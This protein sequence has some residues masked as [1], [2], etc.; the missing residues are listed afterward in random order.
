MCQRRRSRVPILTVTALLG[1][2]LVLP[3]SPA[4]AQQLADEHREACQEQLDQGAPWDTKPRLIPDD[5]CE[6]L[7]EALL[8]AYD[9]A[10][11]AE[12]IR[13]GRQECV[14]ML[15]GGISDDLSDDEWDCLEEFAGTP[16]PSSQGL[17]ES[18]VASAGESMW[19]QLYDWMGSG[20]RWVLQNLMDLIHEGARPEVTAGWFG[21]H[22][23]LMA[24][25]GGLVMVPLL[26]VHTIASVVRGDV[27]GLVRGYLVYTPAATLGT[28][29]AIPLVD[30]GLVVTDA[31]TD[32]FSSRVGD[33]MEAF[34]EG[35]LATLGSEG[36]SSGISL[37]FLTLL[38]AFILVGAVAVWLVLVLRDLGILIA[39]L[40]LPLGF[41]ALVWT[42]TRPWFGRLV[43]LLAAL[44]LSK[45]VIVAVI[46]LG[47]AALGASTS[48]AEGG[49]GTLVSG[50]GLLSLAALAPVLL[51]QIADVAGDQ[52][53]GS[54]E[55]VT[56][57]RTSPVPMPRQ[58]GVRTLNQAMD[59][60]AAQRANPGASAAWTTSPSSYLPSGD[61]ATSASTT[62]GSPKGSSPPTSP[63]GPGAVASTALPTPPARTD[64]GNGPTSSASRPLRPEVSAAVAG[65][66]PPSSAS[67]PTPPP[68]EPPPAPEPPDIADDVPERR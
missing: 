7:V 60:R 36:A 44:I 58:T 45:F 57:Q 12:Q 55:G 8:V 33:N 30:R 6:R 23:G 34:V 31:L 54:V 49:A 25:I 10:E 67:R 13:Q 53:A 4:V 65:N 11:V 19:E 1:L 14:G 39:L 62:A 61:G 41:A 43:R 3:A 50:V 46:S 20:A 48:P 40:L 51:I 47:A 64:G 26:L 16:M 15:A 56:Q 59:G 37:A 63:P 52:L 2:S 5:D 17:I 66:P 21:E 24:A 27:G 32:T 68:R 9:Q 22:F 35:M 38:A 18:A 28:A 42:R 29:V